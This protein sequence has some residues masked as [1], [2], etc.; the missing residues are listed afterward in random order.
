MTLWG[1]FAASLPLVLVGAY[2]AYKGGTVGGIKGAIAGALIAAIWEI[3][4]DANQR[5][6]DIT[7]EKNQLNKEIKRTYED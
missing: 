4:W 3:T 2:G 1:N 7:H 6:V 5:G